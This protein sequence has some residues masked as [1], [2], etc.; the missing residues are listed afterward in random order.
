M[1]RKQ[2]KRIIGINILTIL[3]VLSPFL[4]GPSFLSRPTNIIF[5]L[6]QLGS[7]LGLILIPFGLFW[8]VNQMTKKEN[9]KKKI[10]PILLW[11]VPTLTFVFSIWVADVA[12]DF[13]R[14]I[15]IENADRIIY[16]IEKYKEKNKQYPNEIADLKPDFIKTVPKPWIMG[17][18]GYIYEKKKD[19]YNLTFTQNLIFGFNFEVVVYDPT[20]NHKAKGEL[21]TL[22]DTGKENWKYYVYD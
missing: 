13:S 21:K 16:V 14:S 15:A 10:L 8:T 5:I 6:A 18:S 19:N 20:G 4:P 7:F 12:R 3:I 2:W 17:I 22:Y 11:T 1:T 9:K